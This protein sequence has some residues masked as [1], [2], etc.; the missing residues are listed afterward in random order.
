M[1]NDT[2]TA[3]D[4]LGFDFLVDSLEILLTEADLLPLTVG[5]IGDWG[6]G[7]SSLMAMA[8]DRLRERGDT[9]IVVNFSPWRFEDFAEVKLALMGEV[10]DAIEQHITLVDSAAGGP[11]LAE[12]RRTLG[13]LRA[14]ASKIGLI[15]LGATAGAGLAGLQGQEAAMA[16]AALEAATEI[17]APEIA[18][19]AETAVAP[20]T[21]DSIADFHEVFQQLISELGDDFAALV[22]FIDDMDRCTVDTIIDTFETIRLFLNAP[23]TSYVVGAHEAIITAAL[24]TH[25]NARERG[26]DK[27]GRHYLEKMLQVSVSVPPLSEPEVLTYISLLFAERLL[28]RESQAFATLIGAAASRRAANE[29]DVAMN[30]GIAKAALGDLPEGLPE[31]LV[32]AEEIGPPLAQGLRGNPRQVKR[33]LNT[34]ELR[35]RVAAKRG[36]DIDASVLAKLMVLETTDF[37]S[38]EQIFHWQIEQNGIPKQLADAEGYVRDGKTAEV[39][40]E[41]M[42]WASTAGIKSWLELAPPLAGVALGPYFTY[43]RDRMRRVARAS[44]LSPELQAL[45]A[46]LRS[47]AATKRAGAVKK[48]PGLDAL[49]RAD[50][51]EALLDAGEGDLGGEAMISLVEIAAGD[52]AAADALF[53][54]LKSVNGK[55]AKPK[56]VVQLKAR[57]GSHPELEPLF[58][59]WRPTAVNAVKKAME[60]K[61]D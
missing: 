54:R 53:K 9:Y 15:K 6:S 52:A 1:W 17:A 34:L 60:I 61:K 8:A 29:L 56:L 43:S 4:L 7:K 13:R 11:T 50:L 49:A 16:A 10:I 51:V 59:A 58:D 33:F 3:T 25:Y 46:Q 28:G 2:E 41:L 38:F 36:V 55:S 57:L 22:V 23:R 19:P 30:V 31:A 24:E 18:E 35:R 48:V 45:F 32:I 12:A 42:T 37:E 21:L 40:A 47:P 5:V 26:D 44:K 39:A 20:P 27:L 14:F